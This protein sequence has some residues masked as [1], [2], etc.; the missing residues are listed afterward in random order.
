METQG[1]QVFTYLSIG[2]AEDYR[3]YWINGGW[4]T[5]RPSFVLSE[6]PEWDGNFRVKFWD[7]T[8]QSIMFAR[9]TEAVNRGYDGMYLDIVDAYEVGVVRS[10]YTGANIRQE[11]INFVIAL[12]NH[13]KAINPNFKVV[14]QNAVGLLALNE[15]NP[16]VPNMPYLAA[17]DGI[18]VEDLW[19]D[20][21]QS[22]SWTSG[23]VAF[24]RNAVN[25]NKFVLATSYPTL[26]PLQDAFVTNAIN[27]GYI[28]FVA[29]R[30]LTGLIDSVNNTI[31]ARMLGRDIDTPWTQAAVGVPGL[32]GDPNVLQ[33]T[34]API[35]SHVD[36]NTF[37]PHAHDIIETGGLMPVNPD[38]FGFSN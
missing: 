38:L 30:D 21:N 15:S 17:I 9:V 8:W 33:H 2:E 37:D 36:Y 25:A 31:E 32:G 6:N 14:P 28:P 3:D 19:Y 16:G 22:S 13:A 12:S 35:D 10:A 4:T 27:A 34:A 1:K 29:N 24:L 23:D 7:T 20:G 5:N 11:M 18:G 26:D